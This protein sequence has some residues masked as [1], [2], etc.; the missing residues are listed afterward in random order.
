MRGWGRWV[1]PLLW[2]MAVAV[3]L[4]LVV[5]ACGGRFVY[6]LD[7]PYIHL[8]LAENLASGHHGVNLGEASSPSSSLIWPWLLVPFV[9]T[10]L[11]ELAPLCLNLLAGVAVWLGVDRVGSR[12][13]DPTSPS[14]EAWRAALGV[15][16]LVLGNL[17]VLPLLGM[18]HTLHVALGVWVLV[19]LAEEGDTGRVPPWLVAALV[20]EPWVRYEG[21]GVLVAGAGWLAWRGH[22]GAAFVA[23]LLGLG[24]LVAYSAVLLGLGLD[25]LPTSV[26]VKAGFAERG[27]LG[28]VKRLVNSLVEQHGGGVPLGGALIAGA[29]ALRHRVPEARWLVVPA[30]VGVGHYL[31]GRYGWYGRYE[32]YATLF[33]GLGVAL[34]IARLD[35]GLTRRVPLPALGVGLWVLLAGFG[36]GYVDHALHAPDAAR[37]IHRNQA[38]LHRFVVDHLRGPVAVNDL[39]WVS[40]RNEAYVLD[41]WGLASREAYL[42][43]VTAQDPAWMAALADRHDVPVA[44]LFATWF[45]EV[46]S[47]WTH[48]GALVDE[49][50]VEVVPEGRV[51][52]WATR[53]GAADALRPLLTAWAEGLP[54]G[55]HL[56]LD[57]P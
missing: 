7:D 6:L 4:V 14:R 20:L 26:H 56:E 47:D 10:G 27:L 38:Q 9:H 31:V 36:A 18:E 34:G 44:F 43:R 25:A 40:W 30:T 48:L 37:N 41:L 52:I 19:G 32:I 1:G 54:P 49:G 50:R 55:A 12:L 53:R 28:V 57:A 39:G 35:P 8:A 22:R 2:G 23:G 5:R 17:T 46:P 42:A 51:E 21:V 16:V 13:I 45:P 24:G 11:A 29:L 3:E 15:A 33:V